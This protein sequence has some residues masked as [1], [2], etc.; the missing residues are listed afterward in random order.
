MTVTAWARR[1]LDRLDTDVRADLAASCATAIELHFGLT[2]TPA[3][4][5]GERGA[6]GWC[7]GVSIIDSGVI[8]YRPTASRRQ[9]F[10]LMHELG[11]HLV[12]A[13]VECLS[14]LADQPDPSRVLEQLCDQIA[15]DLLIT[16]ADVD[17]SHGAAVP[18]AGVVF[19]LFDRT[20][21]SRSACAIA[22]ARKLP[23]DGF[24]VL[25]EEGATEVFFASRARDTRPYAWRGDQI[26]A[27]HPLR[28]MPPPVRT[29]AWWPYPTGV[30][31]R[32]YFMS[33][34]T[35]S[36]WTVAVF[37]ENDLFGVANLHLPQEANEDRGYDGDITCPC[38]YSGKTRWWP[39][40]DCGQSQCPRCGECACARRT[41]ERVA[42]KSCFVSVMPHLIEDGMCD[43]CR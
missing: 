23:C 22:V 19:E 37:A 21:A 18:D 15:A 1:V 36:G 40:K 24:V 4:A 14:W 17:A 7:D 34:A 43:S 10:T 20:E 38:G 31:R 42:C 32:E 33:A 13:N 8:L 28:Q 11:H 27:G 39:C 9:N 16:A 2:V 5:F 6:G 35:D 30:E 25:L 29:K 3:E 41:R 26:A 12:D